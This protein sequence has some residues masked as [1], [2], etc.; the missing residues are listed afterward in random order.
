MPSRR[1]ALVTGGTKGIGAAVCNRLADQ[2]FAVA[3]CYLG[4]RDQALSFLR[5]LRRKTPES[6]CFRA[7]VSR[8]AGAAGLIRRVLDR[9]GRLDVLVNGVGPFLYKPL[10]ETTSEEWDHCIRANLSSAFYCSAHALPHLRKSA[11]ASIVNI[12]GPNAEVARAPVMTAAYTAAKTAL[13][14]LT[15]SLARSEAEYGVRV[16]MVN[17]GFIETDAYS[18]R[19]KREAV[20]K[21]PLGRMG[22]PEEVAELVGFI[23]SE[24][25]GY[26]SGAVIDIHGALWL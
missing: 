6:A 11:G 16:N 7:D 1:A 19:M 26:I 21:I 17:P 3:A 22:K 20:R 18:G 13:V 9:F 12:G 25:A 2:G 23:V 14:V 15:K 24:R 5:E 8:A 10:S 4:D